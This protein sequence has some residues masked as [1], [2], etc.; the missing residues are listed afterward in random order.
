M[1]STTGRIPVIAGTGVD[2]ISQRSLCQQRAWYAEEHC[3][4][5]IYFLDRAFTIGHHVWIGSRAKERS[6]SIALALESPLR[7]DKRVVLL[8]QLLF[9]DAELFKRRNELTAS[10]VGCAGALVVESIALRQ[11]TAQLTNETIQIRAVRNRSC[12]KSIG[13][14]LDCALDRL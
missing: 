13:W 9:G 5:A 6:V 3:R 4:R 11:A 2:G 1:M 12:H 10:L 8:A 7:V 14:P